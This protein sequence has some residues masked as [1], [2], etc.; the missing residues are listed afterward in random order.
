MK[1]F[2]KVGVLLLILYLVWLLIV[3]IDSEHRESRT[4]KS[5]NEEK[6]EVNST[7]EEPQP[8]M[9][10]NEFLPEDYPE[11]L[12]ELLQK[13]P[14][15][16]EF[17]LDY[18]LKKNSY[19]RES[20]K[21]LNED[22]I[23]LLI[24]WDSRWGYYLYGDG[25]MGLTGCGPTSLSMVASFLLQDPEL[26]P[27]YMA[28]FATRKG[29]Y[30]PGSGT[31]WELMARGAMELGLQVQVVSLSESLVKEYL[32]RGNPIICSM[33]PGEFTDKGHFIVLTG[34]ENNKIKINDPNSRDRSSRLWEFGEIK[35]QIKNM[36]VYFK[37]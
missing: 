3:Y 15:T 28:D 12:I 21:E 16:K 6:H 10:R 11:E 33:G 30:S 35:S 20:L 36:W 17:V 1:K 25:M 5:E 8:S 7:F 13:N 26:T 24:Q 27:L 29:Y 34:L 2:L 18:P 23:P 37:A 4:C 32:R 22:E 9:G 19:S 14:E 31:S